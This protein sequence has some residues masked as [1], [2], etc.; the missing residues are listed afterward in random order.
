MFASIVAGVVGKAKAVGNAGKVENLLKTAGTA[1]E[2]SL[3]K[4]SEAAKI[5]EGGIKNADV[6]V[7]QAYVNEVRGLNNLEQTLKAE[8]KSA[9]EI[10][11]TL[12]QA[13]RDL[14]V[15]YKDMTSPEMLEQIYD[16]NLNKYGDKLGPTIDYLR[17]KGKTW[18]QIIESAKTP[19]Q[20]FNDLAGIK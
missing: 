8:G 18:E 4:A 12:H 1:E 14:G 5:S 20:E 7:R 16:R 6:A 17:S 19:G 9:E 3:A 15:Q 11:R 10:A 13:R 2:A